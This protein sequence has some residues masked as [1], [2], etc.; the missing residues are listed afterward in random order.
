LHGHL[1]DLSHGLGELRNRVYDERLSETLEE[2]VPYPVRFAPSGRPA[3]SA[4]LYDCDGRAAND[5]LTQKR[6]ME[7]E[8]RTGTLAGAVLDAD[9]L[10]LTIDASAAATQVEDDFREFLRFLRHLE[11]YRSR[12]HTVGGLPVFLVLTKCDLLARDTPTRSAWHARIEDRQQDVARR[13]KQFLAAE[14]GGE[15][16]LLSFG[17]IH[18]EVRATAVRQPALVD[19]A[20][21]PRE[22]HGVAELF[23]HAFVEA[24]T[25]RDRRVRSHK[26]LL[27][28]VGGA[29]SFLVAMAIAGAIFFLNPSRPVEPTLADRLEHL[30]A[31][32]GPTAATR[33]GSGLD[34]RLQAWLEI[35][36]HPAFPEL[37]EN[38]QEVVRERLDEGQAYVQFRDD[39]AA[40][41]PPASARSLAELGQ[42]EARLRKLMPPAPYQAEWAATEAAVERDRLLKEISGLRDAAAH[43]TQFN[44]ALK[45][46]ATS[47][48]Q[49]TELTPEWDQQVRELET[50]EM[51]PPFPRTDP[52]RGPAY[53]FGDVVLA[54]TDWQRSRG[55]LLQLRDVATALGM[56]GDPDE[57]RAP[58]A[59][60]APPADANIAELAARR[61]Q[62]LKT[63]YPDYARWSLA[64]FPDAIRPELE[65]RLRRSIDQSNRDGQ[66]LILE[67]LNAINTTGKE[68]SADW[69]RIGEYLLAPPLKDW[70]ELTAFLAK[71]ADPAVADPVQTTADFLRRTSFDLEVTKLRLR[72]PDT[73]SDA[74]VR[75]NGDLVL[76]HRKNGVAP[77]RVSLRQVGEPER[78]R[79]TLI[80]T[81]TAAASQ[82]LNYVPGDG[83]F[84]ELPVRKGDQDLKLTWAA[85]RTLSYQF[86]RLLRE[87]RLHAANQSNVDG[88]LAEGVIV[89]VSEGKF[90]IVPAMVPIVSLAKK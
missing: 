26:R 5:L 90:P 4:V 8:A 75:P 74:P 35:Q 14:R 2:I 24:I 25:F 45:N 85:S 56:V 65:R 80:Y 44:F 23:H 43:L 52:A 76:D 33:L 54:Q 31:A 79:Q 41:P 27:W 7:K 64:T 16:G 21:Q 11:L 17:S 15:G 28:T 83:F 84:A 38:L 13:F 70:R 42:I 39:V 72:I 37:S 82:T 88:P 77:V 51:S 57:A 47:L 3:R 9:A 87:P 10:I 68:D 89:T 30:K 36:S 29:G 40:T 61:W 19:A 6:S 22:P 20:P 73:L 53:D 86:E 55:Q 18:L 12:Q 62:N 34:R 46:H 48:L 50:A 60:R 81:F 71:L 1:T 32:E 69:P 49:V 78:D 63:R 67:R 66:R 58:L 59:L